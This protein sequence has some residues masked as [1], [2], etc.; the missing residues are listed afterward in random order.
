MLKMF[1]HNGC[2]LRWLTPSYVNAFNPLMPLRLCLVSLVFS[3]SS[4][5]AADNSDSLSEK[6]YCN[7]AQSGCVAIGEWDIRLGVGVGV[8][9]NPVVDGDDLPI[10]IL[11]ELRYYGERFFFDTYTGGFTFYETEGHF[12]NGV[13]TVGFDQ[14]YFKNRSVGNIVIESGPLLASAD[15]ALA[16]GGNGNTLVS[17][18]PASENEEDYTRVAGNLDIGGLHSRDTAA[19]AGFEYGYYRP[20]WEVSVQ[21]LQDVTDVH[22]GQEVRAAAARAFTFGSDSVEVSGG[23][24]WQSAKLLQY[25][26]GI[27]LSEVAD[28]AWAYQ[29]DDGMSP[30]LR[31]DWLRRIRGNWS[32]RATLHHRWLPT[33]ITNSP[34]LDD[35]S[36][37]TLYLGGVYHF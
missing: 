37:L 30:F 5:C 28:P 32:W 25:Y 16:S 14:M 12:F 15:K 6:S 7:S 20:H 19:L 26:Y 21:L 31:L 27:E 2:L 8:R 11:P 1:Y 36:I 29:A 10:F 13:V 35:T 24:S 34:L 23:F 33:Q 22:D 18:A 3:V 9:S 4:L 17:D